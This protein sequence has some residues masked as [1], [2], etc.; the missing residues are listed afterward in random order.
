MDEDYLSLRWREMDIS[1]ALGGGEVIVA[2]SVINTVQRADH[3]LGI[4]G[5]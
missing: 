4:A 1:A 5:V 2:V 3:N